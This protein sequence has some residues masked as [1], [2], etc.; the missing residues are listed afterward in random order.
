[1]NNTNKQIGWVCATLPA[2]VEDAILAGHHLVPAIGGFEI[3]DQPPEVGE[4]FVPTLPPL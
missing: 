1:M 2:H 3:Y 4:A